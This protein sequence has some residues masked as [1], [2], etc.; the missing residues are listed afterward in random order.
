MTRNVKWTTNLLE[1]F[2]EES[3]LNKKVEM[4]SEKAIRLKRILEYRFG[5]FPRSYIAHELHI[6]PEMVD[7]HVAEL[8]KMY[9]E[10]QKRCPDL[11]LIRKSKTEDDMDTL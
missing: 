4:G 1:T 11:P 7:K 3:G 5:E 9:I 8:K 2:L 6:S 10:V